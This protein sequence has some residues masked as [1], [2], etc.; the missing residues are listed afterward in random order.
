MYFFN[1][2]KRTFE[3][4]L[5]RL[6]SFFQCFVVPNYTISAISAWCIIN[7]EVFKVALMKRSKFVREIVLERRSVHLCWDVIWFWTTI[8]RVV[9][10]G[11]RGRLMRASVYPRKEIF[12]LVK[13]RVTFDKLRHSDTRQ[14][15]IAIWKFININRKLEKWYL[16]ASTLNGD[17]GNL[18]S[19]LPTTR[20]RRWKQKTPNC[21][22]GKVLTQ[23][24]EFFS[25]PAVYGAHW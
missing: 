4:V 22:T 5:A 9:R 1:I 17:K 20:L 3:L 19:M 7:C 18:N 6:E 2:I 15:V 14:M 13:D 23:I 8:G 21:A 11:G 10:E 25:E 16:N 24:L 12:N